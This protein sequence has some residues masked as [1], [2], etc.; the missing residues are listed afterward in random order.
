MKK[1]TIHALVATIAMGVATIANAQNTTLFIGVDNFGGSNTNL[2]LTTNTTAGSGGLQLDIGT[3]ASNNGWDG[4]GVSTN[5]MTGMNDTNYGLSGGPANNSTNS[6]WKFGNSGNQFL[7]DYR[8]TNNTGV[9]LKLTTTH[10]DA[11]NAFGANHRDT[12]KVKYVSG[13]LVKGA[14]VAT[15]TAVVEFKTFVTQTWTANQTYQISKGTGAAISGTGWIPDGG[16]ALFRIS[17]EGTRGTGLGQ[18]QIDNLGFTLVG[19]TAA[20]DAAA[21]PE[22]STYAL[23]FGFLSLAFTA[24]KRRIS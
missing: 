18:Q 3:S 13:D 21:V 16:S 14:S 20:L 15:G 11:R 2:D 7:G 17:Y 22:P 4:Y 5:N 19:N 8:I 9:D 1:T 24:V 6:A 23:I 12:L 10:L